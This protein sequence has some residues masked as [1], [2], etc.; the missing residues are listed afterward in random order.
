[1]RPHQRLH[2]L[3][4]LGIKVR[5]YVP[6]ESFESAISEMQRLGAG[7][8]LAVHRYPDYH[9][10]ICNFGH[11]DVVGCNAAT[12]AEPGASVVLVQ[13]RGLRELARRLVLAGDVIVNGP[14]ASAEGWN[15]RVRHR[16]GN[17]VDYLEPT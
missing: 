6:L 7:E 9:L 11:L 16:S 15:M 8:P 17:L 5:H 1:V 12:H 4:I 10:A 3:K 13:V 2:L 14:E